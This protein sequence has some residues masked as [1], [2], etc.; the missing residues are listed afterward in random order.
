MLS[1]FSLFMTRKIYVEIYFTLSRSLLKYN[2]GLC[3]DKLTVRNS[4]ACFEDHGL[5]GHIAVFCVAL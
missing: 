3:P 2:V 5:K 4:E 1:N